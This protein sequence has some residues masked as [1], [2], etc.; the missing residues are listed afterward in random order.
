MSFTDAIKKCF[1][2]YASIQGRASR[3]E[4][5]WFVLFSFI[6]QAIGSLLFEK[7]PLII[8]LVLFLPTLCAGIRRLH[9]GDKSA[10]WLLIALIPVAGVLILI[11]LYC[12]KGTEGVNGFGPNPIDI[13]INNSFKKQS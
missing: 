2:Q 4:Y 8:S 5:W 12:Q 6:V 3:S 1:R 10:W 9:D 7:L 13:S 11:V